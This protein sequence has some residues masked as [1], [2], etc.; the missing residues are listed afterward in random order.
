MPFVRT[1]RLFP[2]HLCARPCQTVVM[3]Q[4]H[5]T[6]VHGIFRSLQAVDYATHAHEGLPQCSHC[7]RRFHSWGPFREHV[8]QR[9][10]HA[11]QSFYATFP[12]LKRHTEFKNS[13]IQKFQNPKILNPTEKMCMGKPKNSK[14]QKLLARTNST[15]PSKNSKIQK[16]H[17]LYNP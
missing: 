6:Q 8:E 1:S 2:R 14:I 11:K 10:C 3:F 17:C 4:K 9:R 13:K 12:N 15:K 5:L 16:V 7:L